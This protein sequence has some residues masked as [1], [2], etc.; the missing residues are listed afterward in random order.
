MKIADHREAQLFQNA[1]ACYEIHLWL[2]G[3][4]SN[5]LKL[6]NESKKSGHEREVIQAK[7]SILRDSISRVKEDFTRRHR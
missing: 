3:V 7:E 1:K 2:Q 6:T 4:W 5:F